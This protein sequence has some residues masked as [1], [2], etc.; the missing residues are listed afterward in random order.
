MKIISVFLDS[1]NYICNGSLVISGNSV[2]RGIDREKTEIRFSDMTENFA[3]GV[4]ESGGT[5]S[6]RDFRIIG[7]GKTS[8][9]NKVG[10]YITKVVGG[11]SYGL[12]QNLK[13]SNFS[14]D[15]IYIHTDVRELR[16]L[17]CV[18][19]NNGG[20]G[21]NANCNDSF[22]E[23]CTTWGNVKSGIRASRGELR[24]IGC[25]SWYNGQSGNTTD[26]NFYG[27]SASELTIDSCTFQ[28]SYKHGFYIVSCSSVN[29]SNTTFSFNGYTNRDLSDSEQFTTY[30]IFIDDCSGVNITN[31]CFTSKLLNNKTYTKRCMYIKGGSGIR[32]QGH[33][34]NDISLIDESQIIYDN[35]SYALTNSTLDIDLNYNLNPTR[36]TKKYAVNLAINGD[37][38][39][40]SSEYF[41]GVVVENNKIISTSKNITFKTINDIRDTRL[42]SYAVIKQISGCAT[43]VN[44]EYA[45]SVW[46]N[47]EPNKEYLL[48]NR[49]VSSYIGQQK[50]FNIQIVEDNCV[51]EII[52]VGASYGAFRGINLPLHTNAQVKRVTELYHS[53]TGGNLDTIVIS[54]KLKYISGDNFT[55]TSIP[56][57][58]LTG[59]IIGDYYGGED[60]KLEILSAKYSPNSVFI[61]T[62]GTK[63]TYQ[64][65]AFES[66]LTTLNTPMHI[67]IMKEQGIYDD[68]KLY[69]TEK[70]EYDRLQ[71]ETEQQ[72]QLA[73]EQSGM[74]NYEE[75]LA[76]QPMML[77]VEN[78]PQPS[79]ALLKFK[80]KYLG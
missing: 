68:F 6:L 75:W 78:E 63:G 8:S 5:L 37:T 12:V 14:N 59:I 62:Q 60:G 53:V 44:L 70:T 24:F 23:T 18:V 3:I 29:I 27:I 80:E 21:I 20:N 17:N 55:G 64:K 33:I 9:S 13:V 32:V 35:A 34:Q 73:F 49:G 43:R 15:G 52:E 42:Y 4:K 38:S 36:Y 41:T 31:V 65:I 10:L 72:R 16:I 77:P 56:S 74:E 46:T 67:D 19:D 58:S 51:F 45:G 7:D 57:K 61:R 66:I 2:I 54:K 25:K 1:N 39:V 11:D 47:G 79:E 40:K 50:T 26:T 30:H 71:R 48:V 28:E 69:F 22:I 76:K